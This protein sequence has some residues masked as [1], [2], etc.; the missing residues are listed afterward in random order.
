[1]RLQLIEKFNSETGDI[2]STVNSITNKFTNQLDECIKEVKELLNS[3]DEISPEQLNYYVSLIPVLLYDL[4]GK[5][6]ELGV[7]S[8]AAK[9]QRK[10]VFNDSYVEQEHGTVSKKTS[11]AQNAAMNEQFIE[12]IMLRAYKE[13]E[14]KIEIATMLHSS[15]KKVQSWK[16]AELEITRTNIFR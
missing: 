15:L 16:T 7:K 13:C 11:I 4:T 9:M 14:N 2:I 12:D 10:Q 3:G 6:T 1:M 8:D 5:I